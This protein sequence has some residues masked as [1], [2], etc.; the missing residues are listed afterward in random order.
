VIKEYKVPLL[1]WNFSTEALNLFARLAVNYAG[2]FVPVVFV[3]LVNSAQPIFILLYG[4]IL[5]LVFGYKKELVFS[6]RE[7]IQKSIASLLILA[8]AYML[9]F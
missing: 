8:G 3:N 1:S 4:I 9:F 5:A 7:L 2:L 6:K